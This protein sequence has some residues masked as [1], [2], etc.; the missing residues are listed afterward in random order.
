MVVINGVKY[1]FIDKESTEKEILERTYYD[2]SN[3]R[4]TASQLDSLVRDSMDA[5]FHM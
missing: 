4:W 3:T 1:L 2:V 5:S